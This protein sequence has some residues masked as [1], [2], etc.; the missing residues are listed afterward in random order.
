MDF[1][2]FEKGG[3]K[4]Y[5]PLLIRKKEKKGRRWGKH[6]KKGTAPACD[7]D[8]ARGERDKKKEESIFVLF[9]MVGGNVRGEKKLGRE[10]VAEK[11]YL[12]N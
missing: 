4:F 10:K 5:I 2:L 12:L 7:L 1:S 6:R 11:R 8:I 3:K 9:L